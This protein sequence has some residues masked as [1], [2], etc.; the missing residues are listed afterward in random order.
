VKFTV[1]MECEGCGQKFVGQA[2]HLVDAVGHLVKSATEGDHAGGKMN[3]ELEA[4][5]AKAQSVNK[6]NDVL[7]ALGMSPSQVVV[8]DKADLIEHL[9]KLEGD[10]A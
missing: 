3:Q 2:E 8:M 10:D 6:V 9:K 5:A 1:T 7:G 4:L